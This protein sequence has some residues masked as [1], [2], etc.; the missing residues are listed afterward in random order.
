MPA[1]EGDA[2]PGRARGPS[3]VGARQREAS[4][5][6]PQGR[7]W[8]SRGWNWARSLCPTRGVSSWNRDHP[9]GCTSCTPGPTQWVWA[10][11]QEP[12][13]LTRSQ[14]MLRATGSMYHRCGTYLKWALIQLIDRRWLGEVLSHAGR[15]S[16]CV[17][18]WGTK[19]KPVTHGLG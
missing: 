2:G 8:G 17:R 10:G 19:G 18:K 16:V 4:V 12:A 7:T 6:F 14:V 9:Q 1:T 11:P 15:W 5:T 3:R 13:F